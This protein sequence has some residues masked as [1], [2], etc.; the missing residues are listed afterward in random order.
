MKKLLKKCKLNR[1]DTRVYYKA[2]KEYK[3]MIMKKIE[4]EGEKMIE[5]LKKDKTGCKFWQTVNQ[6]W[7]RREGVQE[8]IKTEEWMSHFKKQFGKE[9]RRIGEE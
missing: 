2:R 3:K 4:E 5:E 9:V 8:S 1:G 7:K 6:I